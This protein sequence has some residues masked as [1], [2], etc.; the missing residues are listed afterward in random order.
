M[1]NI[2]YIIYHI[3]IVSNPISSCFLQAL[4]LPLFPQNEDGP[5]DRMIHEPS[6]LQ[7]RVFIF[8]IN[9]GVGS[10]FQLTLG[11]ILIYK[12]LT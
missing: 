5:G 11:Q 12:F 9:L 1:Y 7:L 4:L 8:K 6:R 3:Y 2:S 10:C